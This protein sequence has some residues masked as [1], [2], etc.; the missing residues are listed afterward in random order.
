MTN[1]Y[2]SFLTG[3][4]A[5][6]AIAVQPAFAQ[7]ETIAEAKAN[8]EIGEKN[9][10]YLGVV[11]G[12]DITTAVN[13]EMRSI[14][15]QRKAVYAELAEQNGVTVNVTAKLTAEKLINRAPAGSCVQNASG[16]WVQK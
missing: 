4:I 1:F 11:D 13:R 16:R 5:L 9:N 14:N 2:K 12:A 8:C 3:M 10:G 6:V 15:Q 7:S